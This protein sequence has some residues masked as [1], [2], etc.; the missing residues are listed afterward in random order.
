MLQKMTMDKERAIGHSKIVA[1]VNGG[2]VIRDE[3]SGRI[4]TVEGSSGVSKPGPK[5]EEIV[6]N[7]SSKRREALKRLADR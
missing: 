1:S 7:T 5:S 4:L 2:Y 6:K 3:K